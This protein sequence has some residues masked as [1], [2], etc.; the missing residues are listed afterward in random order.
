MAV[1]R[2]FLPET[3]DVVG[4]L[5]AQVEVTLE[6]LD[7]LG[8]WAEGGGVEAADAVRD[9]EHRAD[10]AKRALHRA[11]RI[12][13][14]TPVDAEDLY[15]LSERLDA[16]INGAKDAVR[17]AEVMAMAPDPPVAEMATLLVEGVAHLDD[18][19]AHLVAD[20]D[21]ATEAAD[22]AVKCQRRIERVYRA[23]MSDLIELDDL[24][25]VMSRRELYRRMARLG[26][27]LVEVAERVWYAVVKES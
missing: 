3:P 4:M 8:R 13:F 27:T 17:E 15:W 16:V 7:A 24:R 26:D 2:W 9:A 12:A 5:H 6:G 14:T 23:A 25:E 20:G 22:A 1:K 19:V 11:L 21:E 18:A 10:S